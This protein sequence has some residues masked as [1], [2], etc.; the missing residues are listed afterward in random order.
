MVN[1]AYTDASA[2]ADGGGVR[3]PAHRALDAVATLLSLGT[4]KLAGRGASWLK[5]NGLAK[6]VVPALLMNEAFGA[7]RAWLALGATGWW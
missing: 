1:L 3:H 4:N 6:Y 2:Q 7:Y 5:R